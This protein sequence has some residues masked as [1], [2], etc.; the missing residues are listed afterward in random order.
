MAVLDIGLICKPFC[1]FQ[2]N[3]DIPPRLKKSAH[4]VIL[5]FIRSRPPLNPVSIQ[6]HNLKCFFFL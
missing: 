3:G 1:V 2:V 6:T 4:E 5:E